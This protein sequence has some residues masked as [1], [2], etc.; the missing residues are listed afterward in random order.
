MRDDKPASRTLRIAIKSR[1]GKTINV[2]DVKLHVFFYEEVG[3][4]VV[5]T[6]SKVVPQW[7][8]NPIDWAANEPELLDVEYLLPDSAADDSGEVRKYHGYVIGVYYNNEL[9]DSRADPGRLDKQFPLPLY[10]K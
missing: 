7:L 4:E 10:L 6:E 3:G 5:L 9:Q 8:S 1:P 2:A